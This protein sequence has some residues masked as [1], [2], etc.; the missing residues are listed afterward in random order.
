[1]ILR[2][3]G[4]GLRGFVDPGVTLVRHFVERG[5]VEG[6]FLQCHAQKPRFIASGRWFETN[7]L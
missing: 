7:F 1:M 5:D 2:F 6:K 3:P 4:A